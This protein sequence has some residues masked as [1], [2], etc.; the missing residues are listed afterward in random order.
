[1]CAKIFSDNSISRQGVLVSELGSEL[2]CRVKKECW[3]C[4]GPTT[5]VPGNS[6]HPWFPR[7]DASSFY[8]IELTTFIKKLL[9]KPLDT[10]L[11]IDLDKI[12]ALPAV[13]GPFV[14]FLDHSK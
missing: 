1:M 2:S 12:L 11:Q 4:T 3:F 6:P 7:L 5:D 13:K 8:Q 9:R 10:Q 14:F